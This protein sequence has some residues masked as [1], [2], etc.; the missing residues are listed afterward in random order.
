MVIHFTFL[1]ALIYNIDH[2]LIWLVI[3]WS[4]RLLI[5]VGPMKH[6]N[7]SAESE[8]QTHGSYFS[9]D[10][11]TPSCRL[12]FLASNRATTTGRDCLTEL[13]LSLNWVYQR[14]S[15]N[16]YLNVAVKYSLIFFKSIGYLNYIYKHVRG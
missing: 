10:M 8:M 16:I 12:L 4:Y 9:D 1:I 2:E 6:L 13:C 15:C 7:Q 14:L 3:G 5:N 11:S